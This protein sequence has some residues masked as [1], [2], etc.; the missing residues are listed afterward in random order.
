MKALTIFSIL[1]LFLSLN[2]YSSENVGSLE[3]LI[4]GGGYAPSKSQAV[5]E[6]N[7]KL[8]GSV[9]SHFGVAPASTKI[10]FAGGKGPADVIELDPSF[11]A[12]EYL[13]SRLFAD[14][15]QPDKI[16][17]PN[18]LPKV[19]GPLTRVAL[20]RAFDLL[21]T[22]LS[23][24]GRFGFYFT[25]HGHGDDLDGYTNNHMSLWNNDSYTVQEFSRRLDR[26]PPQ[27]RTQVV[28][29]Q[30]FSGGFAQ[31]NYDGG[32][33][34]GKISA[35]N[36]CGFFAQL[37]SREAAGC[38][39]D[40]SQREEY[41]PYFW[42]AYQRKNEKGQ[43]VDADFDRDGKISSDEAHAYV[44][45]AENSVDVPVS[46]SSQ[47]LRDQDP[48]VDPRRLNQTWGAFEA[49]AKAKRSHAGKVELA[50]LQGLVNQ[51]DPSLV[52][53]PAPYQKVLESIR[54]SRE[55][56]QP[57]A[58]NVSRFFGKLR[59]SATKVRVALIND[60]PAFDGPYVNDATIRVPH[61]EPIDEARKSFLNLKETK[62]YLSAYNAYKV[63]Q[64]Q[65]LGA[66]HLVAKWERLAYLMESE[67]LEEA[68]AK[69]GAAEVQDKYT[70]LRQCE[71]ESFF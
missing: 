36:R 62:A 70:K 26:L 42:A 34:N 23:P 71:A 47:L 57:A 20:D 15:R 45:L 39:A 52:S 32:R 10:L 17:R 16:L 33:P 6:Q 56:I 19:D 67:L 13:F 9:A 49:M 29:V 60:H 46:T 40:L 41:S 27:T 53:D 28:M 54:E 5:L 64:S 1:G 69:R 12:E 38:S 4:A 14:S 11:S 55:K 7:V 63:A 58:R 50:V 22:S 2:A 18:V 37:A 8:F 25:G 51:L 68:L 65:Y 44:I 59:E 48:T 43:S 66:E 24:S 35:A 30:C 31:M 21:E 61:S 3:L